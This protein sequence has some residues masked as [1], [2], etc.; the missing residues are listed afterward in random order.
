MNY[1]MTITTVFR[2]SEDP[3]VNRRAFKTYDEA[4]KKMIEEFEKLNRQIM[5]SDLTNLIG[6]T[7]VLNEW[8]GGNNYNRVAWLHHDMA[9]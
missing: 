6:F 4:C 9:L 1:I 7:V 3:T 8:V 2:D 5:A